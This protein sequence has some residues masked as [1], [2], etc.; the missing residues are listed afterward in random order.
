MM[1]GLR[2]KNK[3]PRD[4]RVGAGN[5]ARGVAFFLRA[6]IVKSLIRHAKTA[7]DIKVDAVRGFG[8]EVWHLHGANFDEAKRSY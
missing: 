5:H 2:P 4:Y 3:S 7:A 1:A 6:A 8:G